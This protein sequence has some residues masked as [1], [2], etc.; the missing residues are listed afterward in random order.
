[1]RCAADL[2]LEI[3]ATKVEN[4]TKELNKLNKNKQRV[5]DKIEK[6]MLEM[7]STT[8]TCYFYPSPFNHYDVKDVYTFYY[9]YPYAYN[10]EDCVIL[11]D[12]VAELNSLCYKT[13]L[14]VDGIFRTLKISAEPQCSE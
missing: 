13:E 7:N 14:S 2:C 11:K 6:K 8:I 4:Y 10:R 12:I 1:M 3:H 9:N 5:L